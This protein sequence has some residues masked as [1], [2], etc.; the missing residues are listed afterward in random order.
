MTLTIL[1]AVLAAAAAFG[2]VYY[3]IPLLIRIAYKKDLYDKPDGDRKIHTR[4][5][6]SLGGV[7]LFIGIYIGFSVSGFADGVEGFGYLSAGLVMLFFTGLKDDMIGLSA[8]KKLAVE[9]ISGLLIIAGSGAVIGGF[10]GVLG[11]SL[12]H[13]AIA[14]P[15]T[16]FTIVVI[17]NAYNLIDGIDGL[18]GG[19]GAIASLFFAVGFFAAGAHSLGVLALITAVSLG[20]FLVHNFNPARIFM[21]DTGSL[22]VGFLLAFMAV[23]FVQLHEAVGFTAIFGNG[24]A[25]LPV[26]FLAIPLYDTLTVFYKRMSRGDGPFTPGKDHIHHQMLEIGFNQKQ[27]TL[28]LYAVTIFI[29]LAAIGL[30]QLN[31]NI[32]LAV[33]LISTFAMLPTNGFKRN[34]VKSVG[35]PDIELWFARREAI[36]ELT[37]QRRRQHSEHSAKSREKRETV[38]A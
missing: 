18:A 13:P 33:I 31:N 14:V 17:M 19:I 10:N 7:A 16:L 20:A 25:V 5:I 3:L 29:S 32:I 34:V 9:M 28:Y 4:Y 1:Q 26:A 23:N 30:S 12:L 38:E 2:I 15:L 21:G 37:M 8:N 22:V 11:V 24:A 36:R 6:S 27:T 35:L